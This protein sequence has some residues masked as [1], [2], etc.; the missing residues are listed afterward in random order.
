RRRPPPRFRLRSR[1]RQAAVPFPNSVDL[2]ARAR[3]LKVRE[4]MLTLAISVLHILGA[5][6]LLPSRACHLARATAYRVTV[7]LLAVAR[8]RFGGERGTRGRTRGGPA[9]VRRNERR[10]MAL[11]RYGAGKL[12]QV[13]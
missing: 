2:A 9:A 6:F 13:G 3:L 4:K 12:R 5:H 11:A 10:D 7:M 1:E 8:P